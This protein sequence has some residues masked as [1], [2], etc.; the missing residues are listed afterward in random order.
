[1]EYKCK[2]CG[3]KSQ[4]KSGNSFHENRCELNPNRKPTL[5]NRQLLISPDGIIKYISENEIDT[6]FANGW[7]K[8]K[9]QGVECSTKGKIAITNG[10]ENKYVL[11]E[12][13][14][15]FLNSGWCR[16]LTIR[17]DKQNIGKASTP[18]MEELRK[19]R[20]SESMKRNKCCG[21]YRHGSGKGKSGKYKGIHCDSTWELA[22]LI[23]HLD[24]N[25]YIE[26]CKERRKYIFN[27][28]EHFY[29]P[30]FITDEGIIEIKGYSTEQ[31]ESKLKQNP[32]IIVLYKDE[33]Q[34]YLEYC[35]NTYKC[36][37]LESLYDE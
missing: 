28:E 13:V 32:D 22:F 1:M 33:I 18:E 36:D 37:N 3:K 24:N 25:L 26:R 14:D 20:I 6:Y 9:R 16:G 34:Q 7:I 2:F 29:T 35:K 10:L 23:Y 11:P 8:Y 21:G 19:Q 5:K 30:D 31:W 4:S 12:I 17:A 27:N 15:E